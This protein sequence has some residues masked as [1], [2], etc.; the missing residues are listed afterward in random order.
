MIATL[1]IIGI[2]LAGSDGPLFPW[3]NIAGSFLVIISLHYAGRTAP[4]RRIHN[5]HIH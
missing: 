5:G 4:T 3:L 1:V 2:I